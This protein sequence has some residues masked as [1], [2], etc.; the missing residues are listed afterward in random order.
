MYVNDL[1][2]DII[3]DKALNK[4]QEDKEELIIPGP[5]TITHPGTVMIIDHDT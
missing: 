2:K 3:E 4:Y 1:E 5:Y